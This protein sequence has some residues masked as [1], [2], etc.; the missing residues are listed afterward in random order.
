M[1]LDVI[2]KTWNLSNWQHNETVALWRAI[3]MRKNV[4]QRATVCICC[5]RRL[6]STALLFTQTFFLTISLKDQRLFPLLSLLPFVRS[7]H[8]MRSPLFLYP[9]RFLPRSVYPNTMKLESVFP[10]KHWFPS[11]RPHTDTSNKII[12]INNNQHEYSLLSLRLICRYS[13]GLL[14]GLP[15]FDSRQE[16]G[17]FLLLQSI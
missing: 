4:L 13:D 7:G 11:T 15:G 14:V 6:L 9:C 8:R 5:F 12:T 17:D 1:I 3:F 2:H 16:T 10:P